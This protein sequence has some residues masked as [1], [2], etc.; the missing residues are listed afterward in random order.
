MFFSQVIGQHR[1]KQQLIRAVEE[2]R[3]SH[4]QL[5]LGPEGSGNLA[6]A[7]SFAQY[8]NC[9]DRQTVAG[10][11]GELS[12]D[13]CG[14]CPSCIK[15]HKVIHPDIH[16]TFP[17]VKIDDKELCADWMAEWREFVHQTP[18]GSYND[19]IEKITEGNKQGNI[20]AKECQE[21]LRKLSLKNYESTYKVQ[22]LWMP[23][24]LDKEGNRLLKILEEPPD[25]T[26]FL[27]VANDSERI[28]NTIM[29]R[30]QIVKFARLG[31]EE[32][33]Q[34]LEREHQLP[35]NQALK[36]A[37]LAGGDLQEAIRLLDIHEDAN[38]AMIREWM[39]A[40][41]RQQVKQLF[42]W[43]EK[44]LKMGREQQKMFFQY[45]MH[46]FREVM[47]LQA[48]AGQLAKLTEAELKTAQGLG[49]LLGVERLMHII[50]LFDKSI[51]F[52]ERN[53]NGKIMMT[54]IS[55]TLLKQFQKNYQPT[56]PFYDRWAL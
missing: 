21:I 45:C 16:Y 14:K 37:K 9:E 42:A 52:V 22:I 17:F 44:F 46:F 12:S 4:A 34:V 13:S 51:Y 35:H 55:V 3:V 24:F 53:V 29:S 28:L 27:L 2:G 23:E 48:G 50:E 56:R 26:V 10:P 6:M 47:L 19:W 25:N 36:V 11:D 32:V 33:A 1:I 41:Y 20:T 31:D 5:F 30:V 7:L 39:E 15:A 8:I 49:Q 54:Y 40:C 38:T 18:Y 43:N